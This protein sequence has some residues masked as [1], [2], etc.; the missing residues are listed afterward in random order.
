VKAP[1]RWEELTLESDALRGNPLGDP[2]ERPVFVWTP[3]AYDDGPERR[4]PA[5]YVLQ[6]MFGQARGWFNVSPFA[7][8]VPEEIDDLSPPAIVV[9]VD[10]FTSVGG[11]QWLDSPA[12][13]RYGTYLCEEV[14]PFVDGRFRT[15]PAREHRGLLG[16]SSGGFGAMTWG[17]RRPDLFGG[18]AT[19]AGD[20]LFDVTI[21]AEFAKVAQ[22]LRNR[23]DGS[24][25]RFWDDF[26]SGRR[27]FESGVDPMLAN[28]WAEACAYSAND[29]GSVD[30]P[31]RV[32]TGE[33]VPGVWERWLAHDPVRLAARRADALREARA[34]WIDA[35]RNDE[36][37]LDL[38]AVAFRE[39]VRAAG[40]PDDRV[41]FELH[42]GT[43]RGTNW[44][45]GLSVPWLAERLATEA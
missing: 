45:H 30:L 18:F 29:D 32:G 26:R 43:H 7:R 20:G 39:A 12:T 36:Y 4:W 23:Y 27:V 16:K 28:T 17:M 25:E 5:L 34:I 2:H 10:G 42:E 31:F 21:A 44:R 8:N 24:Y 9:L 19:H 37:R 38:A 22:E 15:A 41:H 6:G 11:A 13:G 3:P 40:V 14:V 35:G 33:I 1:A